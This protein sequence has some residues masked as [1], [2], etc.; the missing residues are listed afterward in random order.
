MHDELFEMNPD[1][2]LVS[3]LVSSLP[4]VNFVGCVIAFASD[5]A[6]AVETVVEHDIAP[7]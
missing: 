4:G 6:L 1:A 2:L 5:A 7:I 3:L